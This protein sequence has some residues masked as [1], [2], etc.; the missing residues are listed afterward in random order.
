MNLWELSDKCLNVAEEINSEICE[1]KGN[2][3]NTTIRNVAIKTVMRIL[4]SWIPKLNN[5]ERD[6]VLTW[7]ECEY[8]LYI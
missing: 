5:A 6:D 4:D 7:L 8:G 1:C 2:L 3:R